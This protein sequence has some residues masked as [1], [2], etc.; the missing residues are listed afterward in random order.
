M[1]QN[2]PKWLKLDFCVKIGLNMNQKWMRNA[3]IIGQMWNKRGPK[4]DQKWKKN[5]TINRLNVE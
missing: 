5:L 3:P 2:G 4:L 1:D